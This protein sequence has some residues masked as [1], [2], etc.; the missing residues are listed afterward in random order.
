[1]KFLLIQLATPRFGDKHVWVKATDTQRIAGEV[2]GIDEK[3]HYHSLNGV[4][5]VEE[6]ESETFPTD[7]PRSRAIEAYNS[8]NMGLSL[9]IGSIKAILDAINVANNEGQASKKALAAARQ[10]SA[11]LAQFPG[12]IP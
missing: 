7:T 5:P 12:N 8:I 2:W 4:T 3:C 10:L 1:M 11:L 9:T 6:R